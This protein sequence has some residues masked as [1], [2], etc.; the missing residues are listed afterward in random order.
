MSKYIKYVNGKYIDMTVD[1]IAEI[2]RLR[3]ENNEQPQQETLED[4]L[5]KLENLF[6]KLSNFLGVK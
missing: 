2:E 5:T 1:E 4:R 3:A 6:T